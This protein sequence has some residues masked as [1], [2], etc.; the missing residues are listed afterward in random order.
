LFFGARSWTVFSA[1]RSK[2]L[3]R[4]RCSSVVSADGAVGMYMEMQTSFSISINRFKSSIVK[5]FIG[6][7]YLP[8]CFSA[9]THLCRRHGHNV[10][11]IV[12]HLR[13]RHRYEIERLY[14][15]QPSGGSTC[16]S[17]TLDARLPGLST[18]CTVLAWGPSSPSEGKYRTPVPISRRSKSFCK[19]PG[20]I[21]ENVRFD[22]RAFFQPAKG[23]FRRH[24]HFEMS[25]SNST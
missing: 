16:G 22:F 24:F 25:F 12:I 11:G 7:L 2:F 17:S 20:R 3:N 8:V 14:G 6:F 5:F 9:A 13:P 1:C 18:I 10:T 4:I 21:L 19:E 15:P 23:D